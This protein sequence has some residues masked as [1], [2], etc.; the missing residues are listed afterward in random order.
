MKHQKRGGGT[1]DLLAECD[2]LFLPKLNS[3]ACALL[4]SIHPVHNTVDHLHLHVHT[5]CVQLQIGSGCVFVFDCLHSDVPVRRGKDTWY[6]I[7]FGAS[8]R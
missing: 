6:H 5:E 3:N 1:A 7:M 8:Q 2:F 4:Y